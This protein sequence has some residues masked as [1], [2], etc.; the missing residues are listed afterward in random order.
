MDDLNALDLQRSQSLALG[1]AMADAPARPASSPAVPL[2]RRLAAVD[3]ATLAELIIVVLWA[4]VVTRP[5]LTMDMNVYPIGGEYHGAIQIHYIWNE[6][7]Q[8]GWCMMWYGSVG[9]GYPSFVDPNGS[10]LHPLVMVASLIWGVLKGARVVLGGT[11]VLAGLAQWWLGQVLDVGRAAR[12]WAA[13]MVVAAAHMAVRMDGG[14]FPLL[15]STAA[16]SL[17]LPALILLA[18]Q[19]SL[20]N[21]GILGLVLAQAIVSGNGY[22]QV[23]FLLALPAVLILIPWQT[24]SWLR[25]TGYYALAGGLSLLMAAHFILP[26]ARFLPEL[27]K[28]ADTS[29]ASA[30]AFAYVP[31]NLVIGDMKF[32]GNPIL[33]SVPYPSHYVNFIGWVPVLLALWGL[34]GNGQSWRRRAVLFLAAFAFL[35]FW[36]ASAG[37][38]NLMLKY[39]PIRQIG[40]FFSG[41]RFTSFMAALA[42]PAILGLSA[43]GLDRILTHSA[44]PKLELGVAMQQ[45]SSSLVSLS[46]AWLLA[47]P[48]LIALRDGYTMSRTWIQMRPL[49]PEIPAVNEALRTPDLQWVNVP[50]GEGPYVAPAVEA[51]LKLATNSYLTWHWR[52][53]TYPLP[54]MEIHRQVTPQGMTRQGTVAG[55]LFNVAPGREYASVTAPSGERTVCTAQ[56][57]GGNIDVRCDL[58]QAGVLTA[59]ENNWT[60]WQAWVDGQP[61]TLKDNRWLMVDVPEGNHL[62]E[63]RYRPWDVPLGLA[64]MLAGLIVTAVLW[65][66]G[67]ADGSV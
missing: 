9:G 38:Q 5:W 49:G 1:G 12:L 17:A 44:W 51:G 11:F 26:F 27:A 50:Y 32:Y 10:Q 14:Y 16:F 35:I 53:R 31:L 4:V 13:C 30:Q 21:V 56:G 62:I 64:L 61:V 47:I 66:R 65:W 33:I 48:L 8:C 67:A 59:L 46:S 41:A 60:G 34:Q 54:V 42:V 37:P 45:R 20:R 28:D 2:S 40:L 57:M 6:A 3:W 15:V 24:P 36:A 52:D 19:P 29:F 58:T 63:F 25:V 23:A 18:K 39:I 22:H 7:R 43:L 55:M